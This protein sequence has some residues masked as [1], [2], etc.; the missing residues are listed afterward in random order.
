MLLGGCN[1]S[2]VGSGKPHVSGYSV[3]PQPIDGASHGAPFFVVQ[4][5]SGLGST[6]DIPGSART[7]LFGNGAPFLVVGWA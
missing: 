4:W 5:G 3:S 7:G 6:P 1:L 2:I